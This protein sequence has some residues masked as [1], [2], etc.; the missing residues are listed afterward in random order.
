ME[1]E[2][3]PKGTNYGDPVSERGGK[4]TTR[5]VDQKGEEEVVA[6]APHTRQSSAWC[7]RTVAKIVEES[8]EGQR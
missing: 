4:L 3:D 2:R 1:P 6:Y 8:G 5:H 7:T